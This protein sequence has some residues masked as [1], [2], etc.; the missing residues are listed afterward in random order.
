MSQTSAVVKWSWNGCFVK[1]LALNGLVRSYSVLNGPE[2]TVFEKIL[3]PD[4]SEMT[5]VV[6]FGL[7]MAVS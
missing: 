5:V 6:V 4:G 2:M 3:L 1:N 7:E